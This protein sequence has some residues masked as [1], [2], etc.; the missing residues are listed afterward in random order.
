MS[1]NAISFDPSARLDLYCRK[2]RDGQKTLAFYNAAGDPYGIAG[3]DFKL[4]IKAKPG[5]SLNVLQLTIGSGLTIGGGDSN[6]LIIALT[7]T[8]TNLKLVTYYWELFND[9][10][11]QTWMYGDFIVYNRDK[12]PSESSSMELNTVVTSVTIN[13]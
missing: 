3:I 4:N 7:D 13:F 10:T 6:E 8:Q 2:S 11:D 12:G 9:T 5:D 1:T